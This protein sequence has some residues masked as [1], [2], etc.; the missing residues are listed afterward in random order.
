MYVMFCY[1][2]DFFK[3]ITSNSLKFLI[4]QMRNFNKT[5]YFF[6]LLFPFYAF[7][8]SFN[9]EWSDQGALRTWIGGT[10]YYTTRPSE[11]LNTEV[12]I[13]DR[14]DTCVIHK[15]SGKVKFNSDKVFTQIL[16]KYDFRTK[17]NGI[18]KWLI[19]GTTDAY[20]CTDCGVSL[21]G[22]LWEFAD[23][24]W[25]IL[26]EER[27]FAQRGKNGIAPLIDFAIIGKDEQ[28]GIFSWERSALDSI[29]HFYKGEIFT[30]INRQFVQITNSN[31]NL[32]NKLPN[33]CNAVS[34]NSQIPYN[35]ESS[36]EFIDNP[37]N[38]INDLK[39]RQQGT[40]WLESGTVRP[41]NM[42]YIYTWGGSSY[43]LRDSVVNQSYEVY[44]V[45]TA[46]ESF[47]TVAKLYDISSDD[48]KEDNPIVAMR[49]S[50]LLRKGEILFIRKT[51]N[52]AAKTPA[53]VATRDI[54]KEMSVKTKTPKSAPPTELET[55]TNGLLSHRVE[56]GETLFGLCKRYG[57]QMTDLKKYNNLPEDYSIK[58][59]QVLILETA[60]NPAPKIPVTEKLENTQV[61]D[62][63][64]DASK[65][66][67]IVA[68]GETFF[69]IARKY[70]IQIH[71]LQKLNK[72]N[73]Y[74]LFKGQKLRIK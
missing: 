8:Q 39:I 67:H 70:N 11:F 51:R 30:P 26:L 19:T 47:F 50:S 44:E 37:K 3:K 35:Y 12:G 72:M 33:I 9:G 42:D 17:D 74:T 46:L 25:T 57:V 73:D 22:S 62:K 34:S 69:S 65:K 7:G 4:N 20:D 71:V 31:Y 1:H 16:G 66:F 13:I 56:A 59:G 2:T 14:I 54:P 41:F 58:V 40:E 38:D 24:K 55:T 5:L 45:K 32:D 18:F 49:A 23:E 6:T 10:F 28:I 60:E 43:L 48:L 64:N 21:S 15:Y 27:D 53:I 36:Y 61:I 52:T 68:E 63:E 29:Y